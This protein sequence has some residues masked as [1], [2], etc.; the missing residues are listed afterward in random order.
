FKDK[1]TFLR[2]IGQLPSALGTEWK[3]DEFE[4]A[5]NIVDKDGTSVVQT[6][7]QWKHDPLACRE[8]V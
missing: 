8:L 2:K 6:I 4:V 5:G 1:H 3:C 7:E